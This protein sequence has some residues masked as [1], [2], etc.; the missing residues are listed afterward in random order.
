MVTVLAAVTL[1]LMML[2]AMEVLSV[3]QSRVALVREFMTSLMVAM[4]L[5]RIFVGHF[6]FTD[7]LVETTHLRGNFPRSLIVVN[8]VVFAFPL[9]LA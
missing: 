8:N 2:T 7:T 6:A 3:L 5:A 9:L 4:A 1:S